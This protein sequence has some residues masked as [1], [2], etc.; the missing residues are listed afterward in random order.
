MKKATPP[1][2]A[3]IALPKAEQE[4]SMK[5]RRIAAR[6]LYE[7]ERVH[8]FEA[9][10]AGMNPH[11]L[12]AEQRYRGE[13]QDNIVLR[14]LQQASAHGDECVAG[15]CAVLSSQLSDVESGAGL[16]CPGVF[17]RATEREINEGDAPTR[18]Q[19][20]REANHPEATLQ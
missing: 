6:M 18:E 19:V 2:E 11:S 5:G 20:L 7:L 15:F 13:P 17:R 9:S 4:S 8:A 1:K 14:Y 3:G 16:S 10:I 12:F